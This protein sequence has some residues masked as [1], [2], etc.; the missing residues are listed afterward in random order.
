MAT[1]AST[2]ELKPREQ[3]GLL[4]LELVG[5]YCPA[6]PEISESRNLVRNILHWCHGGPV[7]LDR[8]SYRVPL[9]AVTEAVGNDSAREQWNEG[10]DR[11]D[12]SP[13]D[14]RQDE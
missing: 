8:S 13:E 9:V 3:L 7:C 2:G 5:C 10:R 14:D 4:G 11:I 1:R 12:D 6:V